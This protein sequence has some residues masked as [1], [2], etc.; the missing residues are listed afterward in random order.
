[1][2]TPWYAI[3][4]LVGLLVTAWWWGKRFRTQPLM[5]VVYMGGL[6]GAL[7]GA[8]VG[9]LVAEWPF[10]FGQPDLWL[11]AATGKT[12]LGALLGGYVGVE[13]AKWGI[14]Y[15]RATGDAFAVVVPFTLA[16]GRVGCVLHGCCYGVACEQHAWWTIT[17]PAGV[18]HWPAQPVE[19]FFNLAIGLVLFALWRRGRLTGQLFHIYL[20][21]YATFRF[22]HEWLRDTPRL[23]PWLSTY[24][25]LAL[26]LL[27][28]AVW[29]F[30]T[31]AT[32]QPKIVLSEPD[33]VNPVQPSGSTPRGR[34]RG[35]A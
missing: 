26:V 4:M 6:L 25:V 13:A 2:T 12:I 22:L 15:T 32:K 31:R 27:T 9:Y 35:G 17:D 14:G 33:S 18:P 11:K 5:I 30:Q 16:L 19:M 34:K 28:F 21:A 8:K 24:Q 10:E 23:T 7:V 20:I 3:L 29:R 1:M